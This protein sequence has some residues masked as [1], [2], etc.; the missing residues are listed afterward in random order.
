M[1]KSLQQAN[2]E[3]AIHRLAILTRIL[4]S[5][6]EIIDSLPDEDVS[7]ELRE[8]GIDPRPPLNLVELSEATGTA[9]KARSSSDLEDRIKVL[10]EA[11]KEEI[12]EEGMES[13]FT[14]GL[15]RLVEE[16]G[17][18]AIATLA[19]L[20]ES[21]NRNDE[22]AAETLRWVGRLDHPSSY[23]ARLSLLERSL[24]VDSARL[25]DA[26]SVALASMDDEHALPAL[27][28]AIAREEY[29]E[30]REDM[31]QILAQLEGVS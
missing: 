2:S 11:A 5:D 31:Q 12:F 18:E 21:G 15:S 26:A 14:R 3:I 13:D 24:G 22:I 9:R 25:R 30:L 29:A 23:E 8:I 17:A 1:D 20:I 7:A 27:R 16:R 10:L 19:H 28:A 6:P 4:E